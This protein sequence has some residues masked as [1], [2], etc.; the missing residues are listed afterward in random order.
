MY[1]VLPRSPQSWNAARRE[2]VQ[3]FAAAYHELYPL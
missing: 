1:E 2:L 3:L